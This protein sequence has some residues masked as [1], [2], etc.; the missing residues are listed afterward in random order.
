MRKEKK[1]KKETRGKVSRQRSWTQ[2]KR[3]WVGD[4]Q[5]GLLARER[6]GRAGQRPT[7]P[8]SGL[9]QQAHSGAWGWNRAKSL[10]RRPQERAPVPCCAGGLALCQ[11][12]KTLG[13]MVLLES[14]MLFLLGEHPH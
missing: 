5:A 1:K 13:P 11:E 12:K 3:G 10:K 14:G 2:S 7:I 6:G 9:L 4:G 8:L